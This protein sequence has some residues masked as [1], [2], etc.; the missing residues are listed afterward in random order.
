[1]PDLTAEQMVDVVDD[2][3]RGYYLTP[4]YVPLALQSVMNRHFP[5]ELR[6]LFRSAR[7]FVKYASRTDNNARRG[8]P[9]G[10]P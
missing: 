7:M 5:H 3:L 9:D 8:Q 6:R 4:R 10:R 2:M 1:L